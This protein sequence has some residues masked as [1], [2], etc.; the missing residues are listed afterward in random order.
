LTAGAGV[1]YRVADHVVL[2]FDFIDYITGFPKQIIV[3]ATG[4]SPRGLFQQFTPMGGI[5]FTF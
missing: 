2:R 4:A 5:S 3:P 1:K